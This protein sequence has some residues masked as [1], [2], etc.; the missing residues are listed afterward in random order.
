MSEQEDYKQKYLLLSA[1]H[2]R[3]CDLVYEEDGE[4][5][6]IEAVRVENICDAC[7]GTGT[8]VSGLNCMCGGSGKMSDAARYLRVQLVD[9]ML[10][11]DNVEPTLTKVTNYIRKWMH[12]CPINPEVVE[13]LIELNAMINAPP[14]KEKKWCEYC[15]SDTHNDAECNCTRIV[16]SQPAIVNSDMQAIVSISSSKDQTRGE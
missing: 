4:T 15:K 2:S 11:V 6:K 16:P 7:G 12:S 14:E 3:L 13:I 1:Q 5:L 9:A 8:P 10:K